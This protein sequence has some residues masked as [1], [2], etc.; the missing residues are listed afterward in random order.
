MQEVLNQSLN[1]GAVHVMQLLGKDRFRAYFRNFGFGEKTGI[2]VPGELAGLTD[3]LEST[4]EVEYATAAFGQGIAVTPIAMTRA[5]ASLGNG[6]LI[7]RPYLVDEIRFKTL[8][9]DQ[10]ESTLVRRVISE[11][12][13][14]DVTRM[15]VTV[16]DKAL[17]GGKFK[18][19][20]YSIAA[21]TGTAQMSNPAG[22]YYD[23]RYLHSFFGYFPAYDPHYIVFLY[24]VYPKQVQYASETLSEPFANM[25]KFL[26]NY[27][28]IPP[29]R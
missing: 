24:I 5:L 23:D 4:R 15:L 27:Y 18:M 26:I 16:F 25:A 3:N 2:D 29:D 17:A 7:L 28:H 11:R 20:R 6:G 22:G 21:K 13:S 19:D 10:T 12:T 8:E 1:T 14:E 9:R